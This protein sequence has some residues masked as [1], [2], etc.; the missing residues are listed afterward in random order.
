MPSRDQLGDIFAV[1]DAEQFHGCFIAGSN[2]LT[3][4]PANVINGKP[5]RRSYREGGGKAPIHM[6][7]AW[8]C[9]QK[10]VLGQS[11]VSAVS[12]ETTAI[13]KL[14]DPLT[15]KAATITIDVMCYL[16][17]AP[18]EADGVYRRQVVCT[19]I[20]ELYSACRI[21][22]RDFGPISPGDRPCPTSVATSGRR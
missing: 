9:G 14:L 3:G 7:S 2:K 5:M 13:P 4:M 12:N 16:R 22:A 6:I 8:S 21:S 20:A 17:R 15:I 11:K 19:P 1:L 10:L 18:F